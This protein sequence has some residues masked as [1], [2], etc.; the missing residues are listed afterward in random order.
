MVAPRPYAGRASRIKLRGPTR[1]RG[2][3]RLSAAPPPEDPEPRHAARRARA[4]RLALIE[5]HCPASRLQRPHAGDPRRPRRQ[6]AAVA[7]GDAEAVVAARPPV[8]DE[9]RVDRMV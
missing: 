2:P 9:V 7:L 6:R 1:G 4:I 5:P 8:E 3:P